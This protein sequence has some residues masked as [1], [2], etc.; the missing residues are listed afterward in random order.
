MA[1]AEAA[2][3]VQMSPLKIIPV[4]VCYGEK[5]LQVRPWSMG[6]QDELMSTITDLIDAWM[7]FQKD[8]GEDFSVGLMVLKCHAQVRAIC[9]RTIRD[10]LKEIDLTWAELA[11]DDLLTITQAIWG[12]SIIRPGGGGLMGKALAMMGPALLQLVINA[13]TKSD[14]SRSHENPSD[15]SEPPST[16]ATSTT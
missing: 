9:E 7:E 15:P 5:T 13:V 10:E 3:V 8:S 4:P 12:T 14:T 11:G 1:A 2:P 6:V 16:E